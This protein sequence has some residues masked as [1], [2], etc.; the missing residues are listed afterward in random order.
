MKIRP[1]SAYNYPLFERWTFAVPILFYGLFFYAIWALSVPLKSGN[2]S[3]KND[4]DVIDLF[5]RRKLEESFEVKIK[6]S[7]FNSD[8]AIAENQ[9]F[10]VKNEYLVNLEP[11]GL[12]NVNPTAVLEDVFKK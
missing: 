9:L 11:E 8:K 3:L 7:N 5:A 4:R 1:F 2:K 12:G 6:N 10:N